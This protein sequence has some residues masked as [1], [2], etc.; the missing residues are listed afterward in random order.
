MAKKKQMVLI[1]DIAMVVND[2]WPGPDYYMEDTGEVWAEPNEGGSFKHDK[3][4]RYAPVNPGE[5]VNL[6]EYNL[7]FAWQGKGEEKWTGIPKDF[8]ALFNKVMKARTC[9]R[10]IYNVPNALVAE[11]HK[12]AVA[13]G[14]SREH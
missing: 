10:V 6:A 8:V 14:A 5:L 4:G 11:F 9:T 3:K 12:A 13:I 2:H 7:C 1:D